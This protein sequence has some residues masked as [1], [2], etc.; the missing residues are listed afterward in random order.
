MNGQMLALSLRA[1]LHISRF[2][3]EVL[4]GLVQAPEERQIGA[5]DLD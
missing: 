5:H 4:D 2:R 3:T 1:R